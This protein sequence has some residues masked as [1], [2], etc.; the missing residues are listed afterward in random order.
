M[1][2]KLT[3]IAIMMVMAT[4]IFADTFVIKTKKNNKW[5][6][7]VITEQ[8]FEDYKMRYGVDRKDI[9]PDG[10]VHLE[11]EIIPDKDAQ[12][13]KLVQYKTDKEDK[14]HD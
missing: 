1:M 6:S 10:S 8:Q 12:R 9:A 4:A 13:M 5:K 7:Y 11:L 14:A 3:L 2:K